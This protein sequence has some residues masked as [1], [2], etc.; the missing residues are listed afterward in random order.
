MS[1]EHKPN[2]EPICNLI[3]NVN[4]AG[5]YLHNLGESERRGETASWTAQD[6]LDLA[7]KQGGRLA[8]SSD[9][10][11]LISPLKPCLLC[12]LQLFSTF[13][14]LA[15]W[16]GFENPRGLNRVNFYNKNNR[17]NKRIWGGI[18]FTNR[19]GKP[20]PGS[21]N[22][23]RFFVQ[24]IARG[25]TH[26]EIGSVTCI[27]CKVGHRVALLAWVAYLIVIYQKSATK[28]LKITSY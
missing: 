27:S 23:D 20:R 1:I 12:Q 7:I 26:P 25:T 15:P 4:K 13:S 9:T 22:S 5:K 17:E 28:E 16:D 21:P 11:L 6:R 18:G 19:M 2:R 14:T 3:W 24:N 10:S 8:D